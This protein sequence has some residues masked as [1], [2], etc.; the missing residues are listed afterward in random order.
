M[1][2]S[3]L[4]EI[5]TEKKASLTVVLG[6]SYMKVAKMRKEKTK[7]SK[8]VEDI[9]RS[10]R[11]I[12]GNISIFSHAARSRM[13]YAIA[14]VR[15]DLL[16]LFVTLTYP[17]EYSENWKDWKRNL[18]MITRA[19]L[20]EF[21]N[22]SGIWKLEPQRRGAPHY[23]LLVWGVS[24]CELRGLIPYA[25][26]DI[27]APSNVEHLRWH[28][29]KIGNG[30]VHC[31]QEVHTQKQMYM[32]VVK[33]IS[34]AA[35]EGWEYVGKWWGIFGRRNLPLGDEV[36]FEINEKNA[37]DVIRYIRRFTRCGKGMAAVSR[38][39]ICDADQ[40]MEKLQTIPMGTY[41]DWLRK[42]EGRNDS[43]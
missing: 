17:K 32:Y 28:L 35:L 29:G 9:E 38:Q 8:D 31:V 18:E 36:V 34:K 23:H 30:N 14:K 40:W 39:Q 24:L 4:W 21:P 33:Y 16:P 13:M 25:W 43:V 2:F 5:F 27:V 7:V 6:S 15:R 12:R 26:N 20:R 37:D 19:I 3:A 22:A 1:P 41:A 11:P 10:T 42:V